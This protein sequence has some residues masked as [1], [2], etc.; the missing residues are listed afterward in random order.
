[1]IQSYPL[2]KAIRCRNC[3]FAFRF[4]ASLGRNTI[5]CPACGTLEQLDQCFAE[6]SAQSNKS[7][8]ERRLQDCRSRNCPCVLRD[9]AGCHHHSPCPEKK[10]RLVTPAN[11]AQKTTRRNILLGTI[12]LQGLIFAGVLGYFGVHALLWNNQTGQKTAQTSTVT[13]SLVEPAA[14]PIAELAEHNKPAAPASKTTSVPKATP[15]K[16]EAPIASPA[17][18]PAKPEPAKPAKPKETTNPTSVKAEPAKSAESQSASAKTAPPKTPP[19]KSA[20]AKPTKPKESVK[21]EPETPPAKPA[22]VKPVPSKT[23]PVK[24]AEVKPIEKD[25]ASH[26]PLGPTPLPKLHTEELSAKNLLDEALRFLPDNPAKSL[27]LTQQAI[28]LMQAEKA[29]IPYFAYSLLGQALAAHDWGQAFLADIPAVEK[30]VVST[31]GRWLLAQ[32]IDGKIRVWDLSG[33]NQ[34]EPA[35]VLDAGLTPLVD[36]LFANNDRQ[37]IA[38]YEDGAVV[39]WNLDEP[40]AAPWKRTLAGH[41]AG[42]RELRISA[43]GRWLA[44]RGNPAKSRSRRNELVMFKNHSEMRENKASTVIL[45]VSLPLEDALT[46]VMPKND[47]P[48]QI[49]HEKV[50]VTRLSQDFDLNQSV[51]RQVSH[52][53]ASDSNDFSS[54]SRHGVLTTQ[55]IDPNALWLWDL[56]ELKTSG[57]TD[58]VLLHGHQQPIKVLR[59]SDDSRF[60]ASGGQDG[61][62]RVYDMNNGISGIHA[63]VLRG[64]SLDV[65]AVEF[66]SRGHWIATGSRD[67]T[68]RLWKLDGSVMGPDTKILGEHLGW[69]SDLA[70]DEKEQVLV[71][72]GYDK[73]IR[74]WNFSDNIW[75]SVKPASYKDLSRDIPETQSVA[76]KIC[77]SKAGNTLVSLDI[78]GCLRIINGN[79]RFHENSQMFFGNRTL[80]ITNM[81]ISPDQSWLIFSFRNKSNPN[82]S[83]V[84]L[85]PLTLE[86]LLTLAKKEN[87]TF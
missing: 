66:S 26:V 53:A 14:A 30:M 13:E 21:T 77:L 80:P 15:A 64:H 85:W 63:Y 29:I 25:S 82:L 23:P 17:T 65:T 31:T 10:P 81:T 75:G 20:S 61:T 36:V 44:A 1:M 19:A 67:N 59:I 22:E 73:S 39:Y 51:I 72:A 69:I 86:G 41:I 48:G 60:L 68:V 34:S 33:A 58:P 7:K 43:D 40:G 87:A 46:A 27:S 8:K 78:N 28:E 6:S 18:P 45:D 5:A 4:S 37:I 12:C 52:Q 38:G 47:V 84:R 76:K 24:P 54:L 62:V 42:L 35:V 3:H 70:F 71:S 11:E 57:K 32:H 49:L 55:S 74:V 83:G 56:E 50:Q 9:K 79:L 2:E 16:P